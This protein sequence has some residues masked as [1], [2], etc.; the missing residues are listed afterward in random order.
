MTGE[1]PG[2]DPDAAELD[3]LRNRI[4]QL[5]VEIVRL[6][7][8]RARL[9]LRAG[10]LKVRNGRPVADSQRER[11]VLVRVAMANEGPMPQDALLNLY[12]S[13]IESIKRLEELEDPAAE[14]GD[15]GGS[16]G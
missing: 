10:H 4:D 1:R 2:N 11:E 5:D 6:L 9:G 13:L 15:Q 16:D 7:N 8:E 14:P 3:A 12:R